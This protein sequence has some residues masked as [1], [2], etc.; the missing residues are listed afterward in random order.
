M[1]KSLLP[2]GTGVSIIIPCRDEA[3][4]LPGLLAG[5][6]R[7]VPE[8]P[9]IVVD[10]ASRD[11]SA[12]IARDQGATV[13]SHPYAMGNGAAIKTG[14]RASETDYVLCMD[15]DGQHRPEDVPLLLEALSTGYDMTVGARSWKGQAGLGRHLGNSFYNWFASLVVGHSIADLTSGMRAMDRRKALEFIHLLPNG[16]SYPTTMTMAFFRAGYAVRYVSIKVEKRHGRSHISPLRDSIRFLLIIFKVGTLYSPL[17]IFFPMSVTFFML[18]LGYY[19]FTYVTLG[20][21][22]NMGALLFLSAIIT[23]LMGLISEQITS[24]MYQGTH[25]R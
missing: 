4:S 21:F 2:D 19:L 1:S 17:K 3:N 9:V 11:D 12:R 23:F 16:F 22:T 18:G 5:L 7:H 13:I 8:A 24:L 15:A 20:R 6:G 10:D 14:L 25:Q